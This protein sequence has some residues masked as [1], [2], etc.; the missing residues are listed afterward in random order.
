M[1]R[2][3]K[4]REYILRFSILEFWSESRASSRGLIINIF[5]IERV[6]YKSYNPSQ[7]CERVVGIS[8]FPLGKKERDLGISEF[9]F[10]FKDHVSLPLVPSASERIWIPGS[11][12]VS[13]F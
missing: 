12:T 6:E 13:R 1:G 11:E 10:P 4:K 2:E 3:G 5:T 7:N 8:I 9:R